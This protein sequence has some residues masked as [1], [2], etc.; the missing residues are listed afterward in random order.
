ME[1]G[2]FLVLDTSSVVANVAPDATPA[3]LDATAAGPDGATTTVLSLNSKLL[4]DPAN[5]PIWGP[6][7]PCTSACPNSHSAVKVPGRQLI[8]ATD[9]VYGKF[10]LASFGCPWGWMRLI[11][12][13]DEG[14]PT[15]VGEYKI[16]QNE[17]SFCG[18]PAD[19]MQTEQFASFSSHNPTVTANLAVVTWHS[20][21]LQIVDTSDPAHPK[22]AASYSPTPLAMVANED[23]GLGG[24]TGPNK[25]IFWSYPIIKDG[26]IYIIDIRNGLYILRYN[27]LHEDEITNIKFL[28]GNSTLGDAKN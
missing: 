19:D 10:T 16:P 20:G 8:V 28:E 25:V 14:H 3:T 18:T 12:T 5:R 26:L 1:A 9:E 11:S 4:T 23:P 27:G 13:A 15:I 2:H 21:G 22:Q 24:G 6:P 17:Q 7:A